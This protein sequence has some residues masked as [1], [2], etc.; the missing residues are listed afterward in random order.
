MHFQLRNYELLDFSLNIPQKISCI[1]SAVSNYCI[2]LNFWCTLIFGNF[3]GL[4]QTPKF[5]S[6]LKFKDA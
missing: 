3:G 5:K 1:F 6:H 4:A 2:T